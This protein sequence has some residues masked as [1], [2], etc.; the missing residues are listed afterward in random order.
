MKITVLV[1]PKSSREEFVEKGGVIKVYVKAAP[2]DGKANKAALAVVAKKF[3]VAKKNVR[4]V[5]GK[6]GRKKIMEVIGL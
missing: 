1:C 4:I 3:K 6:S 5:V 2:V